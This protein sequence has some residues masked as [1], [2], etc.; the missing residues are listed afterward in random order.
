MKKVK[1]IFLL[2]VLIVAMCLNT[3]VYATA[4]ATAKL[5]SNKNTLSKDE[6]IE[7][8]FSLND[9]ADI[10]EGINAYTGTLVFDKDIFEF[11]KVEGLNNWNT[12]M[13]NSKNISSGNVKLAA[14][15]SN[16][17]K[18]EGNVLKITLKA[19]EDIKSDTTISITN[20]E[21]A[22]LM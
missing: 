19:K 16:F 10:G 22:I 7:I 21:V 14:T 17:T 5:S 11:K 13:Y 3:L 8:F 9:F 2:I 12:P 6:E 4:S 1:I 18:T 15:I 20:L